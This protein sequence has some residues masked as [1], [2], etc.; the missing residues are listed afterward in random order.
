VSHP[1]RLA[2]PPPLN[3]KLGAI[4]PEATTYYVHDIALLPEARRKGHAAQ[5]ADLLAAHARS[6]D[7]DTMSLVAVNNSQTFWERLGFRQ[8][9]I[10]G[11]ETKLLSYGTDAMLMMR[12]LTK[13]DG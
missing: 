4:P 7:F 13:P 12:E 3:S 5:A 9:T 1:W 2:E 8:Q 6:A 11:L 10:P